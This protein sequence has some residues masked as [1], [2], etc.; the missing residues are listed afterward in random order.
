MQ[1]NMNATSVRLQTVTIQVSLFVD[2]LRQ[3]F[4]IFFFSKYFLNK[5][6]AFEN[7]LFAF[8]EIDY[9]FNYS[10]FTGTVYFLCKSCRETSSFS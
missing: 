7:T 10:N 5:A 2:K 3:I 8:P 6:N 4:V 1:G 9:H